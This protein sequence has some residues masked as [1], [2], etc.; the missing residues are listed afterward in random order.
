VEQHLT[1]INGGHLVRVVGPGFALVKQWADDGVPLT[2]VFKG[3][4][5]KAERHKAGASKRP[6]R[7]EFCEA[8]VREVYEDWKR[9]T[10]I[11]VAA[12]EVVDVTDG[13]A[14]AEPKRRSASKAIDKAIERLGRL[15]GR[16]EYPD[17]FRDAVSH[18][19]EQLMTVRDAL[20]R[21]RGAARE[22]LVE[23]LVVI[24]QA[25]VSAARLMMDDDVLRGLREQA[26]RDL[27]SFRDRME[28]DAWQRAVIVTID[29]GVRTHI[30]LPTLEL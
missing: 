13:P 18:A 27:A 30:G 24:D 5:Q 25:L 26:E 21:V 4:E 15:A 14:S 8:D 23:Q 17:G 7:I 20:A 11:S 16:L 12:P 9:A 28:P 19:I 3:I 10:G 22:P 2:V 6:L 1:R 29:R